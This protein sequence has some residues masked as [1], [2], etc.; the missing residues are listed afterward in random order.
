MNPILLDAGGRI[1]S[2][3]TARESQWSQTIRSGRIKDLMSTLQM[4][5][6]LPLEDKIE[7]SLA[8]IHDWYEAWDGDVSY[9]IPAEKIRAYFCGLYARHIPTFLR[10]FATQGWNIL[11]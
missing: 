11:K 7:L 6:A 10:C 4:R 5:R 9:P 8:R 3:C 2:P 1:P